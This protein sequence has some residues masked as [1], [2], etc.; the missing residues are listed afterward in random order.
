MAFAA[1]ACHRDLERLVSWQDLLGIN[2]GL[3]Y[4]L[5]CGLY[6]HAET[7]TR[8]ELQVKDLLW[9]RRLVEMPNGP[10]ASSELFPKD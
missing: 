3:R 4:E 1:I 6:W 5:R 9:L 2:T 7:T 8:L 10:F